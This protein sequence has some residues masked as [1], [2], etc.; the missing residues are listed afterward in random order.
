MFHKLDSHSVQQ[1]SSKTW[2]LVDSWMGLGW[3]LGWGD[4]T[5]RIRF[6]KRVTLVK[7]YLHLFW[8]LLKNLVSEWSW[9]FALPIFSCSCST[10]AQ[11]ALCTMYIIGHT[12]IQDCLVSKKKI[13]EL[14]I[15]KISGVAKTKNQDYVF[16]H[17]VMKKYKDKD[18]N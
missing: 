9:K 11:C 15:L 18:K 6:R 4:Q 7:R 17:T 16:Y 5:F 8:I 12:F 13:H 2:Y 3:D 1:A 10:I 14:Q